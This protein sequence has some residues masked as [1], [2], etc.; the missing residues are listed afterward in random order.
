M[1]MS[2][3]TSASRITNVVVS[4]IEGT[5]DLGT[6]D[7]FVITVKRLNYTSGNAE[8]SATDLPIDIHTHLIAWLTHSYADEKLDV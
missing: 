5:S 6:A 2:T 8:V 1:S 7:T 4:K 3:A